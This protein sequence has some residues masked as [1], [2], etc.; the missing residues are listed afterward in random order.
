MPAFK[1]FRELQTQLDEFQSQQEGSKPEP[2][3]R[4]TTDACWPGY[5]SR[6]TYRRWFK[7][8][9]FLLGLFAVL[10]LM[11]WFVWKGLS[12]FFVY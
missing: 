10:V 8:T 9:T 3:P 7:W 5:M 4:V 1:T 12:F 2:A 11:T 6:A